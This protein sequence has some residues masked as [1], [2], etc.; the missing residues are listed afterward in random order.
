MK[1]LRDPG[2]FPDTLFQTDVE[3]PCQLPQPQLVKRTEQGQKGGD[4]RQ[5]EPAGLIVRWSDGK[6][7]ERA[8]LVPDSAVIAGTHAKAVVAWRNI[9]VVRLPAIAGVLPIAIPAF[10]LVAEKY[11]FLRDEAERRIVDLQIAHQRGQ[12]QT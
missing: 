10:Q 2:P 6:I 8:G 12:R 7:Q 1:F 11:L 5:T 4:A 9:A 3:S